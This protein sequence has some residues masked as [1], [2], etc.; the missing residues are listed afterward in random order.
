ML[1]ALKFQEAAR[2]ISRGILLPGLFENPVTEFTLKI[3]YPIDV[4]CRKC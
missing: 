2:R 3:Y 1:S 4:A